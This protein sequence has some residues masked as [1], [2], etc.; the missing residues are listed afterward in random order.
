VS[1]SPEID[2]LKRR[3]HEAYARLDLAERRLLARATRESA[4]DA[5]DAAITAKE[6]AVSMMSAAVSAAD[7]EEL[8]MRAGETV[9]LAEMLLTGEGVD[10]RARGPPKSQRPGG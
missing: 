2:D 6:L 1:T 7:G 9:A 5:R 3:A 8:A 4:R 10:V